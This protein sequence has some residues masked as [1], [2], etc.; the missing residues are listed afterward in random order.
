MRSIA[1]NISFYWF[2]VVCNLFTTH[3][4]WKAF[5]DAYL[6]DIVIWSLVMLLTNDAGLY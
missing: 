1:I 2:Y 5:F 4:W 6:D 3:D